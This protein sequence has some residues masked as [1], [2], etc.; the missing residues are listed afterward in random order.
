[1]M[2]KRH[3][4]TT[5]GSFLLV[6]LL[7][8]AVMVW[9]VRRELGSLKVKTAEL[10]LKAGT[11]DGAAQRV[12]RLRTQLKE[13]R[14]RIDEEFKTIPASPPAANIMRRLS[15][16]VDGDAVHDWSLTQG[17]VGNA[18]SD[19]EATARMIPLTAELRGEF[20]SVF[21]LLHAAESMDNLV[22]ISSLNISAAQNHR[23]EREAPLLTANV[24]FEAIY[25]P[26]AGKEAR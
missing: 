8:G 22:R 7:G 11:A 3:V 21:D 23:I 24:M 13:K 14:R 15:Q 6:V 20:G 18:G 1:M 10:E 16:M 12:Q 9:P 2:D 5:V 4:M 25:D 19:E 17:M 26:R